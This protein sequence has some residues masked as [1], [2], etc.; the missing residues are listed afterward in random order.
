MTELTEEEKEVILHKKTEMPFS[1]KYNEFF[2]EGTYVCKQCG[3]PLFPSAAKFRAGCGWPSFDEHFPGAVRRVP[4]PN[5]FRTE[6][7]CA[8]CGGHLG[9]VFEGER[10]TPRNTRHCVNS[11]SLRFIPKQPD[12]DKPK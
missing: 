6:I 3:N 4:D 1:G 9:H 8:K 11:L 12:K 10:F 7:I 5:G 2:K